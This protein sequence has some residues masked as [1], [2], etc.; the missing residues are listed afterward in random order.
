M[1][2]G[3]SITTKMETLVEVTKVIRRVDQVAK[4]LP[5]VGRT[6]EDDQKDAVLP[7]SSS[8]GTS[9]TDGYRKMGMI[10]VRGET[11]KSSP[12]NSSDSKMRTI[13]F[14]LSTY[15]R[16]EVG[17]TNASVSRPEA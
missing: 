12:T 5:K 14:L 15:Y 2:S 3:V 11:S 1:T 10:S 9:R 8:K 4:E 13:T 17:S 7:K 6:V 16:G